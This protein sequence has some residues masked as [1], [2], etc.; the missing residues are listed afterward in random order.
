MAERITSLWQTWNPFSGGSSSS[1][2]PSSVPVPETPFDISFEP[3][4]QSLSEL[5]AGGLPLASSPQ[6]SA[7][8][9]LA[10]SP[11]VTVIESPTVASVYPDLGTWKEQLEALETKAVA[12]SPTYVA[13]ATA[14][15]AAA[16][17][18]STKSRRR[19]RRVLRPPVFQEGEEETGEETFA[20]NVEARPLLTTMLLDM[21]LD[22][23]LRK[24]ASSVQTELG[25]K[26]CPTTWEERSRW[27]TPQK[28]AERLVARFRQ[29]NLTAS[30]EKGLYDVPDR[31]WQFHQWAHV[32]PYFIDI[33]CDP[34]LARSST[35]PSIR[36]VIDDDPSYR[37]VSVPTSSTTTMEQSSL[38]PELF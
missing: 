20:G 11:S 23:W 33:Y 24:I 17:P 10:N 1:A 37:P 21:P 38:S 36:V 35:F 12:A 26:T 29:L 27:P 31:G 15:V 22:D 19:P 7:Y 28:V 9:S 6:L 25:M 2:L 34:I 30:V 16:R 14:A 8:P 18:I 4:P 3:I 13:P 5:R 32:A